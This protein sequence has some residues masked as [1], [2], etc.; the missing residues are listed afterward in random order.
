MRKSGRPAELVLP[1][2]SLA[3]LRRALGTRVGADDAAEA[4]REAGH[5]AGDALFEVLRSGLGADGLAQLGEAGFWKRLAELFETRGW[6]ELQHEAVHAGVGALDAADWVEADAGSGSERPSCHFT[7]GLLAN[8]LGHA[9]GQEI[10][11]LESDCRSRGDL[12]CRFLFGAPETL[13]AVHRELVAGR[14]SNASIRAL[15]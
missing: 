4:L 9:A 7:T 3:A 8:L 13:G 11:V 14:D 12:R 15:G 5:A 1:V 10:A 6:G 2:A